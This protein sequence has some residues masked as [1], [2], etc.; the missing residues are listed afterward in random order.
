MQYSSNTPKLPST[1]I[2]GHVLTDFLT[3]TSQILIYHCLK[4]VRLYLYNGTEDQFVIVR[5]T[6][7]LC[8][9][10]VYRQISALILVSMRRK[11]C[12]M[13]SND[14]LHCNEIKFKFFLSLLWWSSGLDR[15]EGTSIQQTHK[16]VV[17][18]VNDS[19]V[20]ELVLSTN[21]KF[22]WMVEL[23][24]FISTYKGHLGMKSE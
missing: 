17:L 16:F 18:S 9:D 15:S 13:Y 14:I 23:E 21:G 22:L 10:N 11:T 8:F 19:K 6:L 12:H 24:I 3:S 7:C 4:T 1:F 20:I 5:S 2:M